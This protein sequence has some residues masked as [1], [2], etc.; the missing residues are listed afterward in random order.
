MCSPPVPPRPARARPRRR[1]PLDVAVV[2]SVPR[3]SS[4]IQFLDFSSP[5][6]RGGNSPFRFAVES[7]QAGEPEPELGLCLI[8]SDA[9][10][11]GEKFVN[12]GETARLTG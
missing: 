11:A 7:G 1:R 4:R 5:A 12:G 2:D 3:S 8:E 6:Q 9:T 10:H